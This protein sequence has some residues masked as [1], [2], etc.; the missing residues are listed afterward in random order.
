MPSFLIEAAG[1]SSFQPPALRLD[2]INSRDLLA[3]ARC[4]YFAFLSA[5]VSPGDPLG[6]VLSG[7][8]GGLP[9]GR[10]VFAPPVL[11][12]DEEFVA[13]DLLRN[14]GAR[15]SVSRNGTGR[16]RSLRPLSA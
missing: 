13:L 12:P 2:R 6:V 15:P 9:R 10:V 1:A 3:A 11:L 14:G 8:E 16:G 4:V 5:T 7:A